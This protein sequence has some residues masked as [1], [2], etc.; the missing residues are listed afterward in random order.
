MGVWY[1]RAMEEEKKFPI[2]LVV[3][4]VLIIA[5]LGWAWW[6]SRDNSSDPSDT[7]S[8]TDQVAGLGQLI[9]AKHQ[10]VDGKH[11][12][13][14]EVDLPTPCSLLE[15][16]VDVAKRLPEQVTIN[17]TA[18]SSAEVCAQVITPTRFKVEFN[19]SEDATIEATWNGAPAN[20]NLVPVASG[21]SIENFEV[22]IKG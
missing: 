15:T 20:L 10:F 16:Q 8:T 17:F 18:T 22:F 2:T 3:I 1:N 13:A 12:V 11:I 21:E 4:I 14:G 19:A 7:A 6:A 9:T 5:G